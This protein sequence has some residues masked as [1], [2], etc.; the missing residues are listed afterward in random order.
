[1][2]KNMRTPDNQWNI[3]LSGVGGQGVITLL[4]MGVEAAVYEERSFRSSEVHGL[5]QRGGSLH[6]HLRVGD[7]VFSP[8]IMPA[9]ASAVI[10]LEHTGALLLSQYM[11]EDTTVL[12]NMPEED[13]RNDEEQET[14]A[15]LSELASNRVHIIPATTLCKEKFGA[16]VVAGVFMLG[17]AVEY[18][19][20][21]Y[22]VETLEHAIESLLPE[23][24][25]DLNRR[26]LHAGVSYAR[27][28]L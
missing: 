15:H 22:A 11:K 26:A 7:A 14:A 25:H 18:G 9:S 23:R 8:L 6:V 28:N 16:D 19:V 13:A 17:V 4:K 27:E 2:N 20:L 3:L 21:P 24:Y 1:M 10:A 5:S 12:I